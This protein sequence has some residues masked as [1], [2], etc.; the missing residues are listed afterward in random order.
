MYLN[1]DGYF[2]PANPKGGGDSAALGECYYYSKFTRDKVGIIL[3]L[4][5]ILPAS[6]LV[7]FQFTPFIR[8]K[9]ILIH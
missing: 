7:C 5:G 9:W 6:I 4:A 2:C 1:I 3:H 8:H